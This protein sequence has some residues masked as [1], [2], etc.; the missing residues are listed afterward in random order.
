MSLVSIIT[1]TYNSSTTI[2]E[3][4]L[5]IKNQSYKNWEWII[6]DDCSVD[7]TVDI[8][9]E[10]IKTDNRV[11]FFVNDV[12]SGAAVARNNSLNNVNGEY[13]AF[14]DSDDL[15]SSDKLEKQIEFMVSND[16]GF[17]FT[18]Y[19]LID[20]SGA[21][22]KKSV[23]IKPIGKVSYFDMLKKKA[24]LGCSTVVLKK[25]K[26]DSISM[27]LIR[28]GQDYALWLNLLKDNKYAYHLNENLMQYRIMPNSIS[29][30]K[31]KKALRQWEI[32]RDLEN[33]PFLFSFKCFVFYAVRAIL[34]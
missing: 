11:R 20:I 22:L 34:R 2:L 27:P 9:R 25:D 10:I 30:N 23:D 4:Y 33:L 5:S 14:I 7:N 29:R 19:G 6:T 28:T 8:I 15:W 21:D 17:S 1:A 3:T 24:T 32:Y 13:I 12:N 16:I 18:G 31:F 26:F